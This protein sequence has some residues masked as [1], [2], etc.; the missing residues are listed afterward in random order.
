MVFLVLMGICFNDSE[1]RAVEDALLIPFFDETGALNASAWEVSA[2]LD[3]STWGR[4]SGGDGL[5]LTNYGGGGA[6]CYAPELIG[7]G[8]GVALRHK[9]SGDFDIQVDFKG[10]S[11]PYVSIVQ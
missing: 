6:F 8:V 2:P 5:L 4:E 9:L 10:F 3:Y 11:G 7:P 1:L